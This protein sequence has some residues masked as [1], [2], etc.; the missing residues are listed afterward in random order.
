MQGCGKKDK[1]KMVKFHYKR[2]DMTPD[3]TLE[4]RTEL[5]RVT[6]I[7]PSSVRSRMTEDETKQ[8]KYLSFNVINVRSPD[9]TAA[10]QIP[11]RD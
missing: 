5:K 3:E 4:N 9:I 11:K 1:F 8:D 10:D 7:V 6:H 2:T